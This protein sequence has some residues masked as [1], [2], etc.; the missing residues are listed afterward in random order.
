MACQ[1]CGSWLVVTLGFSEQMNHIWASLTLED[2]VTL[3][4]HHLYPALFAI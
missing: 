3:H 4:F 1:Q 2:G